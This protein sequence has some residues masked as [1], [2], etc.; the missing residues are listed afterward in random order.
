MDRVG[1]PSSGESI[2][3]GTREGGLALNVPNLERENRLAL[4]G[5]GRGEWSGGRRVVGRG[6]RPG[7]IILELFCGIL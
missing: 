6:K 3:S 4:L 2:D 1:G 5:A 7:T